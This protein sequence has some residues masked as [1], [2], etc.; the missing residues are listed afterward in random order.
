[1]NL[2]TGRIVII[3]G[4]VVVGL[5]VLAN[6][7][8]DDTTVAASPTASATPSSSSTSTKTGTPTDTASPTETPA[9]QTEGVLFMA[10]NGTD[11]AGAGAA[12]QTVLTDD[13][14]KAPQTAAD[15]PVQGVKKTVVYYRDDDNAAQNEADATYIAETYFGGAQVKPLD[16][17]VDSTVPSS[18]T[19]VVVVGEDWATK[20]T[21]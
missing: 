9:P 13:G 10:L 1:M 12:A 3:V 21:Q 2:S 16:P 18:V 19:V 6:G 4:L 8:V 17:T 20:L 5:A 7:F 15:A 11:V 14:Y